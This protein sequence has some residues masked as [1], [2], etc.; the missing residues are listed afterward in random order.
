VLSD[1]Y[2]S[3]PTFS[4][5]LHIGPGYSLRVDDIHGLHVFLSLFCFYLLS[6]VYS[7]AFGL[8]YLLLFEQGHMQAGFEGFSWICRVHG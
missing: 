5:H 6:I 7:F 4:N 3:L 2:K 8:V 1:Y